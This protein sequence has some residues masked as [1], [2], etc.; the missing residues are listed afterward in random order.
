MRRAESAVGAIADAAA[1]WRDADFP[2]RVRVLPRIVERTGYSE[3]VVEY[4]LDA[5][6]SS[7]TAEG[8]RGVIAREV[9]AM[10]RGRNVFGDAPVE[11]VGPVAV[12]SS[13]TTIGVAIVPA[14]FALCACC[15][16]TVKDRED[17]LVS[18][19]FE[20]LA[21]E[22]SG[23]ESQA[24]AMQWRGESDAHDLS[25]YAAVVA[26]G[27]DASLRAI[28]ARLAPAARL[29]PYGP[30]T[31]IGYV[32]REA[33]TSETA[34]RAIADGAARDLVLYEGEGCLSLHALFVERGGA[35]SAESF[36]SI[37]A[38]A[39]E[40]A[41]IE[42]PIGKRDAAVAARVAAARDLALF[43]G[44]PCYSNAGASFLLQMGE[45]DRAPA[46]LPRVLAL[47]VVDEPNETGLYIKRH[48]IPIEA[49][50]VAG[51]RDEIHTKLGAEGIRIAAFGELQ[52]PP[53][54][55][56]HGGRPRFAEFI[57]TEPVP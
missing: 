33:L 54:H 55:V 50:A 7:I 23:F 12:I 51:E 3:P 44:V 1:R 53:L 41:N 22:D 35:L 39:I 9:A 42:F 16:V 17:A 52:R 45:P 36:A 25:A 38:F 2:P 24:R 10:R 46:F 32:A 47:H 26:F 18:A 48:R 28:R 37:L 56:A 6:F 57:R 11:P 13:R 4:A 8:I 27:G 19:F 43:R 21:E 14:I 30:K 31:S 20:T 40:R 34:A 5:L 15:D 29:I 49:C